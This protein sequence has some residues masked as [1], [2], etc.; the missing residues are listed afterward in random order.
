M[1]RFGDSDGEEWF[2][3]SGDLWRANVKRA[4]EGKRGRKALAELREA[5]RAL[6][7]KRLI[8]GAL[9]TVGGMARPDLPEPR[10]DRQDWY[11]DELKVKLEDEG[12]G[13]CAIGA[14]LWFKKVKAGVDPQAA[15]AELPV[16]LDIDGGD[17]ETAAA[18]KAAGLTFTLAWQLAYQNDESMEGMTPEQRYEA[19]MAWIDRQLGDVA[20]A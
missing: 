3:N 17:Y 1:S 10:T 18:G 20:H 6:P 8:S 12:E 2:P 11:R 13:V 15:F 14:Y 7:E 9:C 4:L 19:F 16:L 5:L